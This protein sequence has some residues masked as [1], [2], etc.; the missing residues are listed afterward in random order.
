MLSMAVLRADTP[1]ACDPAQPDTMKRRECSLC[2]E[3]EKQP[4]DQLVFFVK[5]INPRKAN[6][7]LAIPRIHTPG[8]HPLADLS[9]EQRTR[10]WQA[11]IDKAKSLW[12]ESWALAYNGDH[13]RTQCHSHIHI[14]KLLPGVETGN[15]IVV[16]SAAGIPVPKEDGFWIH[17]A[18]GGKMHV[19]TGEQIT[20]TVLLR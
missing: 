8:Q 1:C 20:E 2:A 19:H 12:G 14:G 10:I 4:A 15:F 3:A 9:A 13:V 18:E 6:R 11:S 16:D 7:T 5:D 17:G